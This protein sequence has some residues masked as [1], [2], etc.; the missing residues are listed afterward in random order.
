M[1]NTMSRKRGTIAN[2]L[3]RTLAPYSDEDGL[4]ITLAVLQDSLPRHR[5]DLYLLGLTGSNRDGAVMRTQPLLGRTIQRMRVVVLVSSLRDWL[6]HYN[7]EFPG[8]VGTTINGLLLAEKQY[9]TGLKNLRAETAMRH[10]TQ[11]GR[12]AT[13]KIPKPKQDMAPPVASKNNDLWRVWG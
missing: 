7:P 11:S 6:T 8:V 13:P 9:Q 3:I 1:N 10:G 5:W 2:K 4:Y 12:K